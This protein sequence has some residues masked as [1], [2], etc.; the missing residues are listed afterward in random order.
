MSEVAGES[1]SVVELETDSAVVVPDD[2][3]SAPPAVFAD[4]FA[5]T[6]EN[7]PEWQDMEKNLKET[8]EQFSV[9]QTKDV[10]DVPLIK[11]TVTSFTNVIYD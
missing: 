7:S 6:L 1:T 10:V 8:L 2:A 5:K 9:G 3:N 4:D 11:G